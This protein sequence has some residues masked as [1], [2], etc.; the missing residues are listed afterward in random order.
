MTGL[1]NLATCP[2]PIPYLWIA[3]GQPVI[4]KYSPDSKKTPTPTVTPTWYLSAE[5]HRWRRGRI[6][7]IRLCV[8]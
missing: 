6:N 8:K 7:V 2:F 5:D 3:S 4:R 1:E